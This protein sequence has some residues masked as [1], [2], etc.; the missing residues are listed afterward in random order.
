MAFEIRKE[1]KIIGVSELE[2]GD[3]PMGIVHGAFIPT[4]FYSPNADKTGCKLF[5]KGIDEEIANGFIAIEDYSE[6]LDE[7]F[8]EVTIL[9]NS[10]DDYRKYFKNHLDVYENQFGNQRAV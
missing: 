4:Q 9:I 6:E 8:I 1:D 7:T 10:A 2:F 5:I 3:P